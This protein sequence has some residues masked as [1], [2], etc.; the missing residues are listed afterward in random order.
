[1]QVPRPRYVFSSSITSTTQLATAALGAQR[2]RRGRGVRSPGDDFVFGRR[3]RNYFFVAVEVFEEVAD[4]VEV[5]VG[6]TV[7]AGRVGPGQAG[8]VTAGAAVRV[9]GRCVLA[10]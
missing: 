9:T 8:R 4:D 2:G 3:S 5:V 7:A 1:M 10:A 6:R